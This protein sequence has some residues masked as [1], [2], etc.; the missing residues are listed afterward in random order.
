VLGGDVPLDTASSLFNAY[1]KFASGT[2]GP[3]T[4]GS[5]AFLTALGLLA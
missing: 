4:Q 3:L 5:T 2:A 1:Q